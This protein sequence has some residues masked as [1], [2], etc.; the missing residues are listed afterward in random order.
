MTTLTP[1]LLHKRE[2]LRTHY[3]N[4]IK[5][6]DGRQPIP[7]ELAQDMVQQL[8]DLAINKDDRIGVIDTFLTLTLTLQEHG[9]TNIVVLENQHSSLT[10]L[11]EKY[12]NTIK[13]ACEKIGV[14]Y[15]VPPMNN[16][17]RCDM[18][19]SAIIG[20]PPYQNGN[21]NS[22]TNSLWKEFL[23]TS[24]KMS[25]VVYLVLPDIALAPPTFSKYKDNITQVN[26]DIKKHFRGVGSGFCSLLIEKNPGDSLKIITSDDEIVTPVGS[27]NCV[28]NNFNKELLNEMSDYLTG[29]REWSLSYEY[30][31]RKK[32][33]TDDGKYEVLHTSSNGIRRTDVHHP[34][35]DLIRV[36][37]DVSG[38][39]R[40]HL[41]HNM[42]LTQSHYWTVF[43]TVEEA[44]E[45]VDWGNSEEI[46]SF[47]KKVKWGGM[48]SALIIKNLR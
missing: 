2:A 18:N 44:Q 47:L 5:P 24:V 36:S 21:H 37:V 32:I 11:Q 31:S 7:E 3:K 9:F 39:P 43:E 8:I 34:N 29:D 35:N 10:P 42:G 16:Y 20:N 27:L 4:G 45:Y 14:T 23:S 13:G 6:V 17:K 30:E 19:F 48:N 46:Q 22:T 41:V 12:Y 28:P 33:F 1:T 26:V 38:H 15:Y 25:D 40:F